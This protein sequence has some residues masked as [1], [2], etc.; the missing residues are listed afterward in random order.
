MSGGHTHVDPRQIRA[1][2]FWGEMNPNFFKGT[3]VETQAAEVLAGA[4]A[5]R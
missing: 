1:V 2:R 5:A 4:P 3:Q